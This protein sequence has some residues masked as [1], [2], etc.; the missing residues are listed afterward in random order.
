MRLLLDTNIL[1]RLAQPDTDAA[2]AALAALDVLGQQGFRACIV[3][4]VLYEYWVVCT[5]P[6]DANGLGHRIA[7]V[8]RDVHRLQEIFLFLK[9]ERAIFEQWQTLVFVNE[10]RGKSAHDARLV[11]AMKRHNIEHILTF[12]EGDFQRFSEI[13]I[14]VPGKLT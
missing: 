6:V 7:H 13:I 10:V 2:S 5:R 14:H 11:A 3:P 1:L 4:Q 8:D 9:D 12:N